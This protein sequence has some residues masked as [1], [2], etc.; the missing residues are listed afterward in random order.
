MTVLPMAADHGTVL[1]GVETSTMDV[2]IRNEYYA[3]GPL[4]L[5]AIH[6]P[7]DAGG[8]FEIASAPALPVSLPPGGAPVTVTSIT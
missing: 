8:A 3:N 5:T 6:L 1:A 2:Q 7:S 4:T